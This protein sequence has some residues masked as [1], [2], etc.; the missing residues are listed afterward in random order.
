MFCQLFSCN[1]SKLNVTCDTK[2]FKQYL[3]CEHP[4]VNIIHRLQKILENNIKLT[5]DTTPSS[6]EKETISFH[7]KQPS[8]LLHNIQKLTES[9]HC[10]LLATFHL[11]NSAAAII[12]F[13]RL[14]SVENEAINAFVPAFCNP[15]QSD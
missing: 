7:N 3:L 2:L 13:E 10:E 4:F 11:L 1:R 9:N 6:P 15:K 5:T 12:G 8:I 14:E